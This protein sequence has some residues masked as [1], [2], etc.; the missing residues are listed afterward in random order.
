MH[1]VYCAHIRSVE[2]VGLAVRY[3]EAEHCDTKMHSVVEPESALNVTPGKQERQ[4]RFVKSVGGATSS[5]P[6][7]HCDTG[8]QLDCPKEGW[9]ENVK[10]HG[11]HG[12][13]ESRSP[14]WEPGLHWNCEQA[15]TLLGGENVPPMHGVQR[16]PVPARSVVPAGQVWQT[17][18][19]VG[20]GTLYTSEPGGQ[21]VRS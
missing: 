11:T 20:P 9:Y 3:C 15:P 13:D 12:V 5:Y 4:Y 6:G 1:V 18:F 14:S 8:K 10:L 16:W 2:M 21:T 7:P 17:R 19:A